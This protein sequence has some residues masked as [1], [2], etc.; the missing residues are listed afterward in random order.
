MLPKERLR[1]SG[2]CGYHYTHNCRTLK[3]VQVAA[4]A[5]PCQGGNADRQYSHEMLSD[6]PHQ[7]G[8]Q[9]PVAWVIRQG[10]SQRP[11]RKHSSY[12]TRVNAT[13]RAKRPQGCQCQQRTRRP[14]SHVKA[15][16]LSDKIWAAKGSRDC[17]WGRDSPLDFR[18]PAEAPLRFQ[19]SSF[20]PVIHEDQT[21]CDTP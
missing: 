19:P 18:P 5:E 13:D 14:E 4:S 7:E 16:F 10:T 6:V 3:F 12:A 9:M 1:K 21:W 11:S 15:T 8:R 2:P 20:Q 17:K